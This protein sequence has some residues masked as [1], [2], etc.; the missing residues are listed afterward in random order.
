MVTPESTA[1]VPSE[2]SAAPLTWR[3]VALWLVFAATLVTGLVLA[4]RFSGTV[5][6]IFEEVLR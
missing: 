3:A 5:P 6:V 1:S 4:A 2:N